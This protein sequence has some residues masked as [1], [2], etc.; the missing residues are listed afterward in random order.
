[1]IVEALA[2]GP[3][4][5]VSHHAPNREVIG[6]AAATFSLAAAPASLAQVLGRLIDDPDRR[7]LLGHRA[8]ERAAEHF[9]WATCAERYLAVARAVAKVPAA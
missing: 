6:D 7:A 9:G 2:A 3:P 5:V 1:V 4:L 8:S